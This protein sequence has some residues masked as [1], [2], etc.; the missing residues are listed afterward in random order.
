[1]IL[2]AYLVLMPESAGFQKDQ[3]QKASAASTSAR[4]ILHPKTKDFLAL[5]QKI[6]QLSAMN[7]FKTTPLHPIKESN[8]FKFSIGNNK[9][10][11]GK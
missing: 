7:Y 8:E 6:L 2:T 11:V 10:S 9:I 3:H 1:M 4:S 5:K